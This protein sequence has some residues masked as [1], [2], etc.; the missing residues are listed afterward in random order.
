MATNVHVTKKLLH[1]P[2]KYLWPQK[3]FYNHTK[4]TW[5][6]KLRVNSWART[7]LV[8]CFNVERGS[9][10]LA[11]MNNYASTRCHTLNQNFSIL[12]IEEDLFVRLLKQGRRRRKKDDEWLCEQQWDS[13]L[14]GEGLLLKGKFLK[15]GNWYCHNCKKIVNYIVK[16]KK[17]RKCVCLCVCITF[18]L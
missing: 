11:M 3:R 12:W 16:V 10:A 15:F 13:G 9:L 6:K 7:I 18:F 17:Y 1:G 14:K 5:P 4:S 8:G 2:Q